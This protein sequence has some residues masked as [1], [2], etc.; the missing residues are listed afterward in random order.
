MSV[1]SR[2]GS[3]SR[4]KDGINPFER[5]V[6]AQ[7][8]QMIESGRDAMLRQLEQLAG[9]QVRFVETVM[10]GNEPLDQ[11]SFRGADTADRDQIALFAKLQA[12]A[13][14]ARVSEG[15]VLV[16]V[17]QRRYDRRPV[18]GFDFT[19]CQCAL[20]GALTTV[21]I[22]LALFALEHLYPAAL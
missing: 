3:V 19:I 8:E 13:G 2:S 6:S 5:V 15:L 9:C 16:Y 14:T 4:V 21:A 11:F 10:R 18:S 20:I 22:F 7:Q 17:S 1:R 12:L